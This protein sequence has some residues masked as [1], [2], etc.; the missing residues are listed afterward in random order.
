MVANYRL[1]STGRARLTSRVVS[2][3]SIIL[4]GSGRSGVIDVARSVI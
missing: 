2:Y 1:W 4:I 3:V